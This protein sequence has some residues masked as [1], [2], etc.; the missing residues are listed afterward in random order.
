MYR[1]LLDDLASD[2][3][4]L[5][6]HP[7]GAGESTRRGPYDVQ[8]DLDDLEAIVEFAGGAAILLGVSDGNIRAVRL[9]ARR[10]DLARAV[11]AIAGSTLGQTTTDSEALAGSRQVL[12]AFATLMG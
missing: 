10:P 4:V 7:R 6:Y 8:T 5:V 12:S 3:R 2:H 9:A 1:V 11:V